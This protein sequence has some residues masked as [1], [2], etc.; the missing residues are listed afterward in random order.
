MTSN[1]VGFLIFSLFY[2]SAL[3]QGRP[4]AQ[5]AQITNTQRE[6]FFFLPK[7]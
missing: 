7:D 3:T 1:A 5:E 2:H 6:I 4:T